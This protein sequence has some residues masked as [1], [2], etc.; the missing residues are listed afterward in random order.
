MHYADFD[1][2]S[3]VCVNFNQIRILGTRGVPAAHDGF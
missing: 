1:C 2:L 3:V